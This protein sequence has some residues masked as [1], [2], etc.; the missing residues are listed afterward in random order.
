[1]NPGDFKYKVVFQRTGAPTDDGYTTQPGAWADYCTEWAA[2]SFGTGQERREAAQE[3]GSA[4]ATFQVLSNAK[5][6]A[7]S[8]TDRI[9]FDGSMWDLTSIVPSREFGAGFDITAVRAAK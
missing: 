2:V 8:V 5:T 1:M 6:G 3:A 4:A 7:L 9:S